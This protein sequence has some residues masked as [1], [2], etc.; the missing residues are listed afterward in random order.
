M[1][2]LDGRADIYA[3]GVVMYVMAT[4]ALPF[5]GADTGEI[6]AAH[7]Y[8]VPVPP[9]EIAD[10]TPELSAIIQ[11]CLEKRRSRRYPAMCDVSAALA[12]LEAQR[13]DAQSTMQMP[14][15]P[16]R[17]PTAPPPVAPQPVAS[18]PVA[19]PPVA[20]QPVA[21]LPVASRP[22]TPLPIAPLP[23]ASRP[24][25]P[26]PVAS[27]PVAR[28]PTAQPPVASQPVA[29]LPTAPV[30]WPWR[31]ALA[32]TTVIA[33]VIALAIGIAPMASGLQSVP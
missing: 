27:L 14:V 3:L 9:T 20:L 1:R 4:G 8:C 11:R 25:T 2:R 7:E 13:A 19:P 33:L 6:L 15:A 32:V 10:I 31:L 12:G 30:G 28:L 17:L 21:S 5:T 16:L 22:V 18:Q 26:L 29:R 23:V 24:V